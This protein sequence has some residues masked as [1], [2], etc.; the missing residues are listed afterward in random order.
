M[1]F[2][3]VIH[4]NFSILFFPLESSVSPIMQ[5]IKVHRTQKPCI[6]RG[7]GSLYQL[8]IF[9]LHANEKWNYQYSKYMWEES[10]RL[11]II[12]TLSLRDI[13]NQW[14]LDIVLECRTGTRLL[15]KECIFHRVKIL[16]RRNS[17]SC[18]FAGTT[19]YI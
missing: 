11:V 3:P 4:W 5:S 6:R 2:I 12:T 8:I 14:R 17:W 9:F 16:L 19:D 7:E 1:K 15:F 18:G 13:N 10:L